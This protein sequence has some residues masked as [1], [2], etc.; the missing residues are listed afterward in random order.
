MSGATI[1]LA[2][3]W[4]PKVR[5]ICARVCSEE[6]GDPPCWSL[7][8]DTRQGETPEFIRPCAYC[9]NEEGGVK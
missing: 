3:G 6:F 5:E 7:E 9:E 2:E 4:S 1:K 8:G